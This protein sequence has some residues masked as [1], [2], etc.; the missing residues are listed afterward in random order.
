MH[1]I[2]RASIST[3]V[4]IM[5]TYM[6]PVIQVPIGTAYHYFILFITYHAVSL[7]NMYTR[8]QTQMFISRPTMDR[9]GALRSSFLTMDA[10][11]LH[12][13]GRVRILLRHAMATEFTVLSIMVRH[14]P[15]PVHHLVHRLEM[16]H[17]ITRLHATRR[18]SVSLPWITIMKR[19]TFR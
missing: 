2:P 10:I 11:K 15:G 5:E 8:L 19:S 3:W 13:I 12:A 17:T 9:H 4:H 18:D 16:E 7:V 1:V 14:G 6:F